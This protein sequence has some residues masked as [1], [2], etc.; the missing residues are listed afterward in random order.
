MTGHEVD[1]LRRR[2]FGGNDQVAFV[3]AIFVVDQD[4]HA[5]IAQLGQGLR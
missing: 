1:R 4:H 5:A 2:K 3:L